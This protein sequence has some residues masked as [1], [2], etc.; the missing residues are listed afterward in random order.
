MKISKRSLV[1][2]VGGMG[3][4]GSQF[5]TLF[6]SRGFS[7]TVTGL[8]TQDRND[9]LIADADILIFALPLSHAADLMA[10]MLKNARRK[11][12]LILDVSSLKVREVEA[13]LTSKG[14]VIGMHPLFGPTTDPKGERIILCPVRASAATVASLRKVL[15]AMGLRTIVMSPKEHDDLMATVQVV[16]HLK[17]LLMSDVLRA[18]GVDL[19]KIL[20]LCTPT[21]E[22]EFNVIARFLDDH[23][24]LYMP[25][26]FRNPKTSSILRR[27]RMLIDEYIR[28]AEH[29]DLALAEKRY[30]SCQDFFKPHLKRA[31]RH[32]DACIQTL[33]TLT[34]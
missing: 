32:S 7:V 10:E 17:S 5:A 24:D 8:A 3:K 21:Y 14:E 23:P 19:K 9:A 26:V 28:I 11:N 4:T 22:M 13:M 20:N 30:R 31:R 12:Q 6:H 29:H 25:I 15:G 33:L 1:G 2:I 27:M 16:P 18:S 34:R